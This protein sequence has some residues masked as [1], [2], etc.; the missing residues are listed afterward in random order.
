MQP[1]QQSSRLV[2]HRRPLHSHSA[3]DGQCLCQHR[4][5]GVGLC[6]SSL[7][8]VLY[9]AAEHG[10]EQEEERVDGVHDCHFVGSDSLIRQEHPRADHCTTCRAC[11]SS[12]IRL[13]YGIVLQYA[14]DKTWYT[15]LISM[16]A[17][18][19]MVFGIF[20]T[21]VPVAGVFVHSAGNSKLYKAISSSIEGIR[22]WG[23]TRGGQDSSRY[24]LEDRESNLG[25]EIREGRIWTDTCPA[26][27]RGDD[28]SRDNKPF[29]ACLQSR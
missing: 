21:C 13:Y 29:P 18:P 5:H 10:C 3:G 7:A 23:G 19:E 11:V 8:A 16:W 4:E 15:W 22:A 25:V 1:H 20:V 6:H 9:L 2:E 27:E 24:V 14:D 26:R 17:L 28:V 12:T